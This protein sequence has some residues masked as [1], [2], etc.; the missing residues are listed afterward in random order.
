MS[1]NLTIMKN[2]TTA[3]TEE[4]KENNGQKRAKAKQIFLGIDAHLRSYVVA[5]K[6]DSRAIQSAQRF[7]L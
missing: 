4:V 6:R 5:I 2:P 3:L 1:S 7:S